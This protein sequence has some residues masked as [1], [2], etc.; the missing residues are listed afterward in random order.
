MKKNKKYY[1]WI[2]YALMLLVTV[3]SASGELNNIVFQDNF[4]SNLNAW[5]HSG[6]GSFTTNNGLLVVNNYGSGS[7]W[8]GPIIMKEVNV[9]DEWSASW[10]QS[11]SNAGSG[12]LSEH[13]FIF[14]LDNNDEIIFRHSDSWGGGLRYANIIF[15][16]DTILW[17]SNTIDG[18]SFSITDG[19]HK[20]ESNGTHIKM[21]FD[22]TLRYTLESDAK[23]KYVGANFNQ[24]QEYNLNSVLNANNITVLSSFEL[25]N[26][27]VSLI[28][29]NTNESIDIFSILVDGESYSTTDGE[30]V[31][32]LLSND[33][34]LYDISFYNINGNGGNASY[35][36]FVAED[37]NV[38]TN[39]EGEA[40]QFILNVTDFFSGE[41]LNGSI[42]ADPQVC[43]EPPCSLSYV[44]DFVNG[45]YKGV[46]GEPSVKERDLLL[47]VSD[48]YNKSFVD[49]DLTS[50]LITNMTPFYYLSDKSFNGF[51][52]YSSDLYVR[53]LNYSIRAV[54][55]TFINSSFLVNVN[56]ESASYSPSCNNETSFLIEGTY[57]HDEEG[58]FNISFSLR[59]DEDN[60]TA[61]NVSNTTFISDL[62]DPVVNASVNFPGGFNNETASLSLQCIDNVTP[63][64]FYNMVYD[65]N[66]IFSGNKTA[67]T[68]QS[69]ISSVVGGNNVFFVSCDDFFGSSFET[70]SSNVY[71]KNISLIDEI[72]NTAFD[73]SNLSSARLYYDDNSSFY[74]FKEED[75]NSVTFSSTNVSQLRLELGYPENTFITRWIDVALFDDTNNIRLCANK[76]DVV[77]FEQF[78]TSSVSKSVF[79]KNI[80]ANCYV[81]GDRT[82]FAFKDAL[83]LRAYTISGTYSLFTV[84]GLE[85]VLLASVDGAIQSDIFLDQLQ[86]RRETFT[87][88]ILPDLISFSKKDAPDGALR[89][90]YLNSNLDNYGLTINIKNGETGDLLFS[91]SSFVNYNEASLLF[92]YD[93][94][95]EINDSTLLV[96]E[97]VKKDINNDETTLRRYFNTTGSTGQFR[98]E[99]AGFIALFVLIFGFTF[100]SSNQ[101]FGWFGMIIAILTFGFLSFALSAW[102]IVFLQAL[103]ASLLIYC[104]VTLS[105]D[106]AGGFFT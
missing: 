47:V 50:P 69:N 87:V 104:V 32:D 67:N 33:T 7:S 30:I 46:L 23:L 63:I 19:E 43:V 20:M 36:N 57:T 94:F 64:I 73:V 98:S 14:I 90:Y 45:V 41:V 56:N 34:S 26:F 89:I 39:Y 105:K 15:L 51:F 85:Q 68:T 40:E 10:I 99:L 61:F 74:D 8:H 80:Y 9:T 24:F 65:S 106:S 28:D 82:R 13:N 58:L 38:S 17:S 52:N 102:Y 88:S 27:T 16:N 86:F 93:T 91:E 77:H 78:I 70:L 37:V 54:C 83:I 101:T 59:N 92:N 11:W 84:D 21:Y 100:T 49:Y 4:T 95:P 60:E 71:Y 103:S 42:Y 12:A 5:T 6:E 79:L 31:T 25:I 62:Y 18:T 55:P 44:D 97:V 2:M 3:V 96:L 66:N 75:K 76:D 72:D 53:Q 48:Y 81:A 35:F 22:G 1:L 29:K